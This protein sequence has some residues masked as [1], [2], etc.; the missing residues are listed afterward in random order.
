MNPVTTR[1][2]QTTGRRW[3]LVFLAALVAV[4]ATILS[5][6]S[7]SAA[8]TASAETRVRASSVVVDILVEPPQQEAAGQPLGKQPADVAL[9]V[10]TGVAANGAANVC[11][12]NNF[13]GDTLVLMADGS[14]KP[15]KD[16]RLGDLVMA[17][18]PITGQ[19]GPRR[20]LDLIRHGGLHTMVA[21]RLAD[22][23]TIDSTDRH[24]FWVTNRGT[25]GEWVD[26]IELEPGDQVQAAD[27]DL[28]VVASTGI[29]VE[30]VRAFNLTVNDLHTY[31]VGDGEVLVHNAGCMSSVI[32]HLMGIYEP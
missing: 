18:D 23:S 31:Y 32:N 25:D 3:V 17:T 6:A 15:I 4:L 10:A 29:R 11:K 14:K 16:V 27:N 9:V 21:I 12:V 13:T 30:D 8:T 20:V 5:S 22:G 19:R 7:A 1:T 2:Q 26:A 24:P 28:L